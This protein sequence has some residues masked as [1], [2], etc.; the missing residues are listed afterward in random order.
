MEFLLVSHAATQYSTGLNILD[1][2]FLFIFKDK[3]LAK[4]QM[5]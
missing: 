4:L 5:P 3:D 2:M 1:N